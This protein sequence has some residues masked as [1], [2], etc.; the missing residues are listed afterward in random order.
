[1]NTPRMIKRTVLVCSLLLPYSSLHS[2]E[3]PLDFHGRGFFGKYLNSDTVRF[4]FDASFEIYLNALRHGPLSAYVYYRDDL[5]MAEQTG[6]VSIDP[7]YSHYYI[8]AGLDYFLTDFVVTGY[9]VHDCVHD[10]D[11]DVEGTPVFNRLRLRFSPDDFHYTTRLKTHDKFLWSVDLG[12]YPTWQ[13]HGW[14]INS[15]ADY[16]Y[17][18]ILDVM[19]NIYSAENFGVDLRPNFTITKGDTSFYHRHI[20]GLQTYYTRSARRFG[21][22]LE[23]LLFVNDPIKSPDKLWLLSIYSEF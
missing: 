17:D 11:Y 10:I 14:D 1:M 5:D 8:V 21:L 3:V 13:Y 23:Y 6:G 9:F 15:G 22:S 19:Y 12:Y 18:V 16:R 7:R 4:N 2:L 20:L